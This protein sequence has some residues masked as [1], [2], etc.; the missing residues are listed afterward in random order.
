M[1]A[2]LDRTNT[3]EVIGG[4]DTHADTVH[5]AVVNQLGVPLDNRQF[6]TTAAGYAAAVAFLGSFG[7]PVAAVGI[8]GTA[9][10]GA[11]LAT[12]CAGAGLKVLEVNRPD[13]AERR[14]RGKSD[15]IDAY[16]AAATVLSGKAKAA[17]KSQDVHGLRSVQAARRAAL[18]ASTAASNQIRD[19]L[20]TA[21]AGLRDKYAHLGGEA[22]IKALAR[23]R[24]A[25]A[26]AEYRL[27]LVAL[28]SLA[29][30]HQALSAEA[31]E[32]KEHMGTEARAINPYLLSLPGVGPENAAKLL[33]AAGA[34]PDRLRSEA[35]FAALC[36]TAPVP[37]S[38]GKTTRH[39]YSRGGDRQANS[40]LHNIA[41][42]RMR[43]EQRTRDYVERQHATGRHTG[44]GVMRKLK[45][46]IAREMYRAL[47]NPQPLPELADLRP[48]RLAKKIT[49]QQAA[50]ALGTY[51]TK[52]ART[53][54]NTHP[55]YDLATRYRNWLT[56]AA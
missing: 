56:T 44:A 48:M 18:K 34:N 16:Q 10:Y 29:R 38:S 30:R 24:P 46:A 55:D 27:A 33:I 47:T 22:R 23:C 25:Q 8:E 5:V 4:A 7:V 52:I 42:T 45:R 54:K 6:D 35:S 28:K 14:A 36:G 3:L 51:P 15:P 2:T 12:A 41:L 43:D 13:R 11:G 19:L 9:S 31:A 37:A 32:L 53:E 20:V 39:R 26:P 49:L 50:D 1:T 17:P 21:P 40:A